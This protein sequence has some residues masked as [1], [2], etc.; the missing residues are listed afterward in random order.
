MI[1]M[2]DEHTQTMNS[3][4]VFSNVRYNTAM[5]KTVI[6]DIDGTLYDYQTANRK[7]MKAVSDYVCNKLGWTEEQFYSAHQQAFDDLNR[8]AYGTA[9][10]HNR[11]IRYG[12]LAGNCPLSQKD[13]LE[14][15]ERY[16]KAFLKDMVPYPHLRETL[17]FLKDSH[18]LIGAGTNMTAYPQFLKLKQL[19]ILDFFDFVVTSEEALAEKP[20]AEFFL[21][22]CKRAECLPEECLFIGDEMRKD[23]IG[24]KMCGMHALL[25]CG[26]NAAE[27]NDADSFSSYEQFPK[28]FAELVH[29]RAE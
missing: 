25:I 1:Y 23:I 2:S 8:H 19:N 17:S 9:A 7:G 5:I 18:L 14:M 21:H 15:D 27:E 24:A 29:S 10:S 6:F 28:R 26:E 20:A 12:L 11:L 16:W 13:A 22:C 4:R 3:V